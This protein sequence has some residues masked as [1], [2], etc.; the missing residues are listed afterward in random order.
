MVPH[1][2]L[3]KLIHKI[4][5]CVFILELLREGGGVRIRIKLISTTV[6]V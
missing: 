4:L 1:E 2:K 5:L 6:T 3:M